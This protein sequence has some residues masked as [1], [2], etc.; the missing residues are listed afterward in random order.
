MLT[1]DRVSVR[2]GDRTAV[3][4]VSLTVGNENGADAVTKGRGDSVTALLGPS[5]CGKSTLLRAVA[6]LEPLAR[7]RILWDGE[8]LAAVPTHRRGFGVVFQDGQLFGHRDVA[9]NIRY[10]LQRH[11]WPRAEAN[12]RVDELLELVGLPGM[13]ARPV[14]ELS[15]GQ[16]QRVALARALAPRPRLL[17]LDEP[18]SALDRQLRDR[19]VG[20]L[21]RI[22]RETGT[23]ALIV[24][25]DH[26]EAVELADTVA[27][28]DAGELAQVDRPARLWRR[29]RTPDVARFLGYSVLLDAQVKDLQ[30]TSALGQVLV[31]CPDGRFRLGLRPGS[32]V[33]QAHGV[34]ARVTGSVPTAD[35]VRITAAVDTDDGELLVDALGDTAPADGE[36][37]RVALNPRRIAVVG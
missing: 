25:H 4:D 37:V 23:P 33:I 16:Q 20:D 15:G 5:G 27:V 7:G 35:G 30:A 22:L 36:V 18:L 3:R 32:V 1:I 8:D 13:G 34:P 24:T 12:A 21:R 10:G 6:G 31:D 9:G 11:H 28:L 19:L 14:G 29:P 2:Y 17:L 26:D